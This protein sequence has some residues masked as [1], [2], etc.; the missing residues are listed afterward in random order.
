MELS[1]YKILETKK[2]EI[3][4][5]KHVKWARKTA[6]DRTLKIANLKDKERQAHKAKIDE[7]GRNVEEGRVIKTIE[8][9]I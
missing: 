4:E 3:I 2:M 7:T 8:G 6:P 9:G 5:G 1:T